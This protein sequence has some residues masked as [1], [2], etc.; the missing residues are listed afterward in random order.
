MSGDLIG[1]LSPSTRNRRAEPERGGVRVYVRF[2]SRTGE[3]LE[4]SRN[5]IRPF[6]ERGPQGE[7][8]DDPIAY[9][10]M[11]ARLSAL[12]LQRRLRKLKGPAA[13]AP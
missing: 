12:S 9:F 11:G 8:G 10:V 5:V 4:L 13:V 2:S 6:Y 1:Y 3:V 7:E